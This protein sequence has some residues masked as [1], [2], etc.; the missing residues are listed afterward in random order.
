[1]VVV[2]ILVIALFLF[3]IAGALGVPALASWVV[4]MRYALAVMFAA[5]GA[6]HF[7]RTRH[8]LARMVPQ[9]FS[10]PM[11]IVYFTGVCEFAGAIGIL[12]PRFR[13]A[14]GICLVV[15]L[16]ALLPANIK[17]ARE[18]LTIL[19]KPATSLW[20][21]I[22]MQIVFIGLVWGSTRT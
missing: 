16:A 7:N 3:R 4:A 18:G 10:N 21:R 13:S 14:A 6:A 1:M 8:E 9:A 22:P 19:G 5:T 2:A 15:L 17:A 11:A 20:L 12:I